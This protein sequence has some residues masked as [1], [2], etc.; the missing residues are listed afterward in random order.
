MIRHSGAGRCAIRVSLGER[1][2]QV[3]VTDDGVP[4]ASQAAGYGLLGLKERAAARGG[5]AEAGPLPGNRLP[6]PHRG[7]AAHHMIRVLLAEDQDMVRGALQALLSLEP[8]LEVVADVGRGDAVIAAAL[9]TRPDVALLDIEMPG[10]DGISAARALRE[11]LPSCHSLILTTF[12][13]P[14][15]LRRAM[16]SGA[17]GFLLKDAPARELAAAIRRCACDLAGVR[18]SGR[19]R[20]AHRQQQLPRERASGLRGESECLGGERA[21]QHHLPRDRA[22]GFAREPRRD[23]AGGGRRTPIR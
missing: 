23:Q 3:E 22:P 13:R 2:A 4:V 16:E 5:V 14:G 18:R 20:A 11:Q 10:G 19:R 1:D 15:L 21:R 7:S 9:R 17:S 6:P 12:G 8:D